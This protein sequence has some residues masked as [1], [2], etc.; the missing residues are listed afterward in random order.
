MGQAFEGDH[1][2][3]ELIDRNRDA[4]CLF[5]EQLDLTT[6]VADHEAWALE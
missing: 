2:Q 6:K 4:E 5:T 3:I 1:A